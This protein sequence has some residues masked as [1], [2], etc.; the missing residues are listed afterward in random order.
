M[1]SVPARA[2]SVAITFIAVT[3]AWVPF[4]AETFAQVGAMFGCLFPRP[5]DPMGLHSL[6]RFWSAQFHGQSLINLNDWFKP[7]ELWPAVL[8]P[9]FLSTVLHPVG[10]I[11][12]VI[13]LATF[14]MPNTYEIFRRFDPAL[15]LPKEKK[16]YGAIY[17]LDWRVA[18]ALAGAFVVSVLGLSHVSPFLYFQF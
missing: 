16:P 5:Q 14:L 12:L 10:L 1:N 8:P 18:L 3:L 11:V 9:D 17:S 2:L 13:G 7:R 6:S 4:R 15:N